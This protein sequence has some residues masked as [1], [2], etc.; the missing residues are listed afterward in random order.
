M[1]PHKQRQT[2]DK[3]RAA[4][5][6]KLDRWHELSAKIEHSK[7][8]LGYSPAA[9]LRKRESASEQERKASAKFFAFLR[10]ISPRDWEVGCPAWWTLRVLSF[11]DA[12]RPLSEPLS[13]V[14]PLA[15][16]SKRHIT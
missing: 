11:E 14:P 15:Y 16:G 2:F 4:Y 9:L 12:T 5:F 13:A 6:A 7:H 8:R 3:L 1:T 10:T